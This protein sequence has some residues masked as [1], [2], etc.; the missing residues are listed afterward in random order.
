MRCEL[1]VVYS[2]HAVTSAKRAHRLQVRK[3]LHQGMLSACVILQSLEA[4]GLY[5]PACREP[6]SPGRRTS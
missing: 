2:I 4:R 3:P 6:L 1:A 5:G